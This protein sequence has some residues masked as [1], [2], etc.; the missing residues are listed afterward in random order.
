MNNVEKYYNFV[1][2]TL[3]D[4][5]DENQDSM[6]KWSFMTSDSRV[7]LDRLLLHGESGILNGIKVSNNSERQIDGLLGRIISIAKSKARTKSEQNRSY[8]KVSIL[9]IKSILKKDSNDP[10]GLFERLILLATKE[11]KT[12]LEHELDISDSWGK[13]KRSDEDKKETEERTNRVLAKENEYISQIAKVMSIV[14]IGSRGIRVT[15]KDITFLVS[16]EGSLKGITTN[17]ERVN[18]IIEKV[19]LERDKAEADREGSGLEEVI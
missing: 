4:F 1:V 5:I 7:N 11:A 17:N 3:R 6:I 19:V 16:K 10:D 14:D 9:D 18:K 12:K 13:Q 8:S 15:K 2:D